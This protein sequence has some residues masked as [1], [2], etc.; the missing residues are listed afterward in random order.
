MKKNEA[1]KKDSLWNQPKRKL[2]AD[3]PEIFSQK[4]L[5][6]LGDHSRFFWPLMKCTILRPLYGRPYHEGRICT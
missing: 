5:M 4:V 1:N 3:Y 2:Y 6:Y